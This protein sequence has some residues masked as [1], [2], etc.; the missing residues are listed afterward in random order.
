MN[1]FIG[2]ML[3]S[4]IIENLKDKWMTSA[5][6]HRYSMKL[7]TIAQLLFQFFKKFKCS[8]PNFIAVNSFVNHKKMLGL[9]L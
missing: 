6:K 4:G 2:K 3:E 5:E 1:Y 9:L 7:T 8:S